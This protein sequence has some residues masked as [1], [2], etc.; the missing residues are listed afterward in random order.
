MKKT[1]VV[2]SEEWKYKSY[3]SLVKWYDINSLVID[4]TFIFTRYTDFI[5]KNKINN[6][7]CVC[8]CGGGGGGGRG[9]RLKHFYS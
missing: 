5:A 2:Q 8:V 4:A 1:E 7:V 6:R 9:G 3:Q